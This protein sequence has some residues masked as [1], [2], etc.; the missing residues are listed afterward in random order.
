MEIIENSYDILIR[1]KAKTARK[2]IN[3]AI[4]SMIALSVAYFA[5]WVV[6][7]ADSVILDYM[8]KRLPGREAEYT[9]DI[10]RTVSSYV[11]RNPTR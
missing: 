11:R 10:L 2:I 6:A 7:L 5:F 4:I 1:Q 3:F 8:G 9:A